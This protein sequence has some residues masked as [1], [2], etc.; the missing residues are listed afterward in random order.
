MA[1]LVK[2]CYSKCYFQYTTGFNQCTSWL[3]I[4]ILSFGLPAEF[5]SF[6]IWPQFFWFHCSLSK[7]FFTL[8]HLTSSQI[9][10]QINLSWLQLASNISNN[11][12]TVAIRTKKQFTVAQY[13]WGSIETIVIV[14]RVNL[15][16]D[17]FNTLS[18]VQSRI[19]FLCANSPLNGCTDTRFK[20][21]KLD[22]I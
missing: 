15:A 22:E 4:F 7:L 1:S 14:E 5:I 20:W 17:L 9:T 13:G 6:T 2:F 18:L 19:L 21:A 12:G 10:K 8:K 3:G 11:T 16:T